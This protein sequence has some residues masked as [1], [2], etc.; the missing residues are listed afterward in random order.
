[1]SSLLALAW[2]PQIRGALIVLTAF[3]ILCGSVYLLLMT[4]TGARLGFLLAVAGLTGWITLMA[5]VWMVFGIGLRGR[6][7]TWRA[8]EVIPGRPVETATAEVMEDFPDPDA[9]WERLD[10]SDGTLA[11]AQAAADAVLT[12]A[13]PAG[14]EG[15]HGGGADAEPVEPEFPPPFQE[16]GDYV[17][18]AGYRKG[19]E[20]YLPGGIE[21]S[22]GFLHRPHYVVVQVLPAIQNDPIG[23][24]APPTPRPDLTQAP[25]TV[26]M[27]RDL[28]S[29]RFP[30]LVVALAAGTIFG[31]T[32]YVLHQ[33]D[34][35][36]MAQRLDQRPAQPQAA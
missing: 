8:E 6:Q 33:R 7:A 17:Q 11:D 30:P 19:G 32:C 5:V 34:K 27:V 36:I 26:V 23:A 20:N 22:R 16:P 18:V 4:N 15:G 25:T 31:V 1:M 21:W 10:P 24:Q 13:P 9:G 29:L 35:E 14:Q 12:P 28:G 2:D 3:T